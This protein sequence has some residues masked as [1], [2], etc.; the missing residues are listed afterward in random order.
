MI[1]RPSLDEYYYYNRVKTIIKPVSLKKK[2][3]LTNNYT[4]GPTQRRAAPSLVVYTYSYVVVVRRHL[5][6]YIY[7]L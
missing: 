7:Y 6:V 5:Y 2:T 3:P 1:I 4:L